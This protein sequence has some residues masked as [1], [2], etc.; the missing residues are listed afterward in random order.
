MYHHWPGQAG[1]SGGELIAQQLFSYYIFTL[2]E[3]EDYR[4]L[5]SI[6]P[7]LPEFVFC[8]ALEFRLPGSVSPYGLAIT[9]SQFESPSH[10]CESPGSRLKTEE[11]ACPPAD[12]FSGRPERL[13]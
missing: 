1:R 10:R 8:S 13:S 4:W 12:F 7:V 11:F 3:R 9:I 2:H 6:C 5:L